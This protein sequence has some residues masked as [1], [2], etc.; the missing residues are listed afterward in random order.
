MD[1]RSDLSVSK[2]SDVVSSDAHCVD[3]RG[4]VL[5]IN[6]CEATPFVCISGGRVIAQN[7]LDASSRS[8]VTE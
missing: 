7:G 4:S 6:S 2:A 5:V 8:G 3:H 1:K